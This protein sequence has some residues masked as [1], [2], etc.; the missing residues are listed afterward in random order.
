MTKT[1]NDWVAEIMQDGK[2][3]V[4]PSGWISLA[5]MSRKMGV[6]ERTM[7]SR[8]DTLVNDGKLQRKQFRIKSG[9]DTRP[10]WHYAP[11]T[12]REKP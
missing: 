5:D 7:R 8:V 3:E 9:R 6:N 2:P 4:V 1:A 10:V 11:V 12:K